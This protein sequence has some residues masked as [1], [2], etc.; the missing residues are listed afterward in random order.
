MRRRDRVRLYALRPQ[1]W[2]GR[3]HRCWR[4]ARRPPREWE[5]GSSLY[6]CFILYFLHHFSDRFVDFPYFVNAGCLANRERNELPKTSK[7]FAHIFDQRVAA[8][9][10]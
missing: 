5:G 1:G 10:G 9:F 4:R 8:K 6:D 2:S 3:G 7:W